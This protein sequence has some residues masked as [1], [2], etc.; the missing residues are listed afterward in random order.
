MYKIEIE[1]EKLRGIVKK[2]TF[3]MPF[4]GCYKNGRGVKSNY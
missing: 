4:V 1:A 2:S 3:K